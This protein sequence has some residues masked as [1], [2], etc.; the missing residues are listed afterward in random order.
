MRTTTSEQ[1]DASDFLKELKEMMA[2]S[3]ADMP[4]SLRRKMLEAEVRPEC[5]IALMRTIR[6]F[7]NF[8]PWALKLFDAS[9]K[10][11]TGLFQGSHA[12]LGAF[13]ECLETVLHDSYGNVMAR[14]QYCKLLVYSKNGTATESAILSVQ[15]VLHP[16][17]KYFSN[18]VT[19]KDYPLLRMAICFTDECNQQDFQALVNVVKTPLVRLEVSNCVTADPEPWTYAQIAI[20][21][22][23]CVL[24]VVVTAATF[25]DYIME[26]MPKKK[27]RYS[28][29]AKVVKAFSVTSNTRAL[30]RVADKSNPD[31]YALQFLHGMRFLCIGHIVSCHCG[32]TISDSWSRFLNLLIASEEWPYMLLSA[33]FSSVDTFFFQSGFFLCLSVSRQKNSGPL[34]FVI[35]VVR[36]YISV[37]DVT[38]NEYYVRPYYHAICYFSGCITCLLIDDFRNRKISK[39]SQIAGWCISFSC[40]L[41]CVFMKL[42]WYRSQTPPTEAAKLLAAFFDRILWSV[43]L[44]WVTLACS[45]GRGGFVNKLLSWN[46]FVAPSKLSFGVYL[47][48]MPFIRLSLQASRERLFWSTFNVA[49]MYFSVLAWSYVLAYFTYLVCEAPTTVLDKLAFARIT[50]SR[51][52]VHKQNSKPQ[53]NGIDVKQREKAADGVFS[54][55]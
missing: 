3:F 43:F 51:Q 41:C 52:S 31:H 54:R 2:R 4:T 19:A 49:S 6:A 28:G 23:L 37:M 44:I 30:L 13:D 46:V 39:A 55:L 12:D 27:P 50:Q 34:A 53:L 21:I 20:A 15:D 14:G 16:R 18:Y 47:I 9:G 7:L 42:S 36:R 33:G 40:G 1:D 8:E 35:G 11:P 29:V 26:R 48:H 25:M 5:S 10:Y 22:F 24:L 45:T 17:I 38:M 32:Q